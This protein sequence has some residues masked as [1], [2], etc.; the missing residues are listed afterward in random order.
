ML[1]GL[2]R[3]PDWLV[4]PLVDHVAHL[5]LIEEIFHD[6]LVKLPITPVPLDRNS[7]ARVLL[8]TY[9]LHQ[10]HHVFWAHN[11]VED[12]VCSIDVGTGWCF[13]N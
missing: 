13:W 10:V 9:L 6:Q 5:M 12:K 11:P 1:L 3:L 7:F 8:L 2:P 4:V